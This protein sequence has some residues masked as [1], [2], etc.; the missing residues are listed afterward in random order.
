MPSNIKRHDTKQFGADPSKKRNKSPK[1][2]K[3]IR[4]KTS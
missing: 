4:H 3:E 1:T 2:L